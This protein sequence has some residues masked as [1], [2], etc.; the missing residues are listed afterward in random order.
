MVGLPWLVDM[1]WGSLLPRVVGIGRCG[2]ELGAS[3]EGCAFLTLVKTAPISVDEVLRYVVERLGSIVCLT[4]ALPSHHVPVIGP[5][6]MCCT[7]L[8]P[9]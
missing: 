9:T 3:H 5:E 4:V 1:C 2:G 6:P 8:L 7:T